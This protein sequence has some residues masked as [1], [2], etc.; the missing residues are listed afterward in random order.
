VVAHYPI[1]AP[2]VCP[3]SAIVLP[4]ELPS[5]ILA[6]FPEHV[7]QRLRKHD[8]I[9]PP[10]P[11]TPVYR[12]I[13]TVTVT[14]PTA[15][16]TVAE[17]TVPV[18]G[19]EMDVSFSKLALICLSHEM[20]CFKVVGCGR[21]FSSC[22]YNQLATCLHDTVSAACHD[23]VDY[24]ERCGSPSIEPCS[25]EHVSSIVQDVPVISLTT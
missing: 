4:G 18:N 6:M 24:D 22:S 5:G 20:S 23:C 2:A 14:I 17:R 7:L 12:T 10:V 15:S 25:L 11:T 13:V 16:S 9:D 1:A 8:I 3:A 21:T 19:A